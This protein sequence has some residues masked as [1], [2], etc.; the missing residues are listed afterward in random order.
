MLQDF[1]EIDQ[2]VKIIIYYFDRTPFFCK[3]NCG[4]TGK[5]F[6]KIIATRRWITSRGYSWLVGNLLGVD[7]KD[8]ETGCKF[9]NREAIL[10]VLEKTQDPHWFWDTEIMVRSYYEGLKIVE[11]TVLFIR[12]PEVPSTVRLIKDSLYSFFKLWQFRKVVTDYRSKE[13]KNPSA[14]PKIKVLQQ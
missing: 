3:K 6:N 13:A 14:V 12:R 5:R 1:I 11:Y 8:T 7:I 2:A 10:P 9:F 4:S